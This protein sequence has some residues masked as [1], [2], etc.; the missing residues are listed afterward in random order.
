MNNKQAKI[1]LYGLGA[2][3]VLALIAA[4]IGIWLLKVYVVADIISSVL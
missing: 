4:G 1:L 3:I 2:L